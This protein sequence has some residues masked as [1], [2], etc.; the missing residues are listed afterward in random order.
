MIKDRN[1]HDNAGIQMHKILG[2]GQAGE[3]Y[4][5]A[6]VGTQA[7]DF[8]RARVGSDK[9]FTTLESAG[10]AAAASADSLVLMAPH[11]AETVASAAAINLDK[12]GMRVLGLGEGAAR[13][14]FTFSATASTITITAASITMKNFI[15]V[16]SIDSVVSAI[17]VSA[18]DVTLDFEVQ[19]T[20]DI[21]C[22]TAVLT[23][24]DADRLDI[25]L[26]YL[27]YASGN[28]VLAP[29]Q[30]VGC[31]TARI[32]VD[33]YGVADTAVVNFI[34]TACLNIDITGHF[35][36]IGTSLTKN[37]VDTEGNGTWSVVGWD[38]NSNSNF[39]GGDAAAVASDDS[40]AIAAAVAVIDGLHDVPVADAVTNLYMRDVVGIKTDAAA[41]GA[42]SSVESLM[43]YAKQI[44]TAA[45]TE[46]AASAAGV[47][48]TAIKATGDMTSMNTGEILFTVTGDV[49]VKL[50]GSVDVAVT[51][52]S[53]ATTIEAGIT[54]NTACL[55]VQDVIDNTAFAVGDSWTLDTAA[56]ANGAALSSE[57]VLVG[58][59]VDII[60]T[61]DTDDIT[62]G[63]MDFY[64]QFI[65]ASA[66][67]A[68][69]AA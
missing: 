69:V 60:L 68:V 23:T 16:P 30:L 35:N 2:S 18:A 3:I 20:T 7:Y 22:V 26:K 55:C 38:G 14:T 13:P 63:E 29:I 4:W 15:V 21:E 42:V 8:L 54:G 5:V 61:I 51:S 47:P 19:D 33:F 6:T 56:D 1:I 17:V 32:Y 39:S 44:V 40:A 37:V 64:C 59:G 31:D 48:Q 66:D 45:I 50:G 58:N 36:N 52:T 43:A 67:G 49:L 34:T 62:A 65:P 9:L 12:I 46:A 28:A 53:G 11:H 25:R 27:G 57:W 10:T 24:A 41:A